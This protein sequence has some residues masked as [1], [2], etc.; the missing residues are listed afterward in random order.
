MMNEREQ[1]PPTPEKDKSDDRERKVPTFLPGTRQ[2]GNEDVLRLM[3]A[4]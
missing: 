1:T 3:R 4:L 2:Q